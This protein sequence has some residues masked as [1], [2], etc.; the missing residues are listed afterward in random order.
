MLTRSNDLCIMVFAKTPIPGR[1]K[2]RLMDTLSAEQAVQLHRHLVGHCLAT[3]LRSNTA[4][5]QLWCWPDVEDDLFKTYQNYDAITLYAQQGCDLGER[6]F[7][8]FTK[9]LRCYRY[10]IVIGTDCPVLSAGHL[11]NAVTTLTQGNQ[12]VLIPAEDG[13]Y[14]LLGLTSAHRSLFEQFHWGKPDVAQLTR[15]RLISLKWK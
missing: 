14:V 8:A 13:G 7:H 12:A 6:M 10:V 9:A 1:V 5:I 3:V 15:E 2:T 4:D 11:H